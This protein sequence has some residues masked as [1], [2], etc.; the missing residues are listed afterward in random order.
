MPPLLLRFRTAG[1]QEA[2][3]LLE[4]LQR[5]GAVRTVIDFFAFTL[6]VQEPAPL[7]NG[8]VLGR[9]GWNY[10]E[11]LRDFSHRLRLAVHEEEHDS[12]ARL[13]GRSPQ[14]IS[15][16]GVLIQHIDASFHPEMTICPPPAHVKPDGG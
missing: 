13:T 7:H 8:Q 4:K 14:E 2:R 16:L 9:G 3:E 11:L 1:C 12:L 6:S 5:L 10:I 15:N